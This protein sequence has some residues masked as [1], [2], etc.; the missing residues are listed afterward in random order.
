MPTTACGDWAKQLAQRI[1]PHIFP[2]PFVRGLQTHAAFKCLL[3]FALCLAALFTYV[4]LDNKLPQGHHYS[5]LEFAG[6]AFTL[7]RYIDDLTKTEMAV[8]G[9]SNALHLFNAVMYAVTLA[10]ASAFCSLQLRA[11]DHTRWACVADLVCW[12]QPVTWLI[13]TVQ[14][15][16]LFSQFV[17]GSPVRSDV[18]VTVMSFGI[19]FLI[20]IVACVLFIA[21]VLVWLLSYWCKHNATPQ[22]QQQQHE[23]GKKESDTVHG[24]LIADVI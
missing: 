16:L 13:Y 8:F 12:I 22:Q 2:H 11:A 14:H 24:Q 1:S 3:P 23:Q 17:S 19:T 21:A 9:F 20:L 15:V 5:D 6:S 7:Q 4:G 10:A 18:P